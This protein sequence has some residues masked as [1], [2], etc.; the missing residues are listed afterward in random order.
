MASPGCRHRGDHYTLVRTQRTRDGGTR[1]L[2]H[3]FCGPCL[4]SG[5]YSY[6][7]EHGAPP[8]LRIHGT[9]LLG[10]CL[11]AGPLPGPLAPIL[12]S[13]LPERYECSYYPPPDG[14]RQEQFHDLM[15]RFVGS[16]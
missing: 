1:F 9:E 5:L 16:E 2:Y 7:H 14:S 3:P 12:L 8:Q 15:M 10:M 13:A 4:A 11:A 6:F